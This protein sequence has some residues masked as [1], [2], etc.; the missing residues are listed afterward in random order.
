MGVLSR[1]SGRDQAGSG[2]AIGV[3]ILF[4]PLMG[5]I[6][7]L[8]MLTGSARV[9]QALQSTANRA[10]RTASLCCHRTEGAEG[11]VHAALE[12]AE[13]SGAGN[14]IVCNNDLVGE[15]RIRFTDVE[16]NDVPIGPE[17]AVPP[18]GTV[19]VLLTCRI[20]TEVLGGVGFPGLDV[21][22]RALGAASIDPFRTRSGG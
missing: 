8:S 15:S 1:R 11:A 2:T 14:R 16:G 13:R 19:S 12:A 18:G 4:V 3:A 21:E 5:V 9:E 6:V 10:A 17:A 22:R 7:A 20:P